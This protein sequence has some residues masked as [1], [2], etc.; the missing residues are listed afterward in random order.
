MVRQRVKGVV[1]AEPLVL[2]GRDELLDPT[3]ID[4]V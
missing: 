4:I 3:N 1:I 2:R